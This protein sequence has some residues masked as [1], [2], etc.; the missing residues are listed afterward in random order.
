MAVPIPVS[1]L[2]KQQGIE[3]MTNIQQ[4]L[5]IAQASFVNSKTPV[6]DAELLLAH[7]LNCERT[8]LHTW[9]EKEVAMVEL[10]KYQQICAQRA[11]GVPIAYLLGNQAFWKFNLQVTPDVLIP[12]PETELIV[13]VA[14]KILSNHSMATV[15]DLGTGSGAIA[16]A[17]AYEHPNWKIIATD[18]SLK[19]LKIAK[20]NAKNLKI[21]SIQWV[22]SH[23]LSELKDQCFDLIISNPPYIA[24]EDPHLVAL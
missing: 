13:E 14:L 24:P 18:N 4:A 23:W 5:K 20:A 2:R 6:L 7:I 9:P 21:N 16:L 8:S 15:V 1:S 3:K 17:L 10:Q 12:R 11:N 19:A 22:K